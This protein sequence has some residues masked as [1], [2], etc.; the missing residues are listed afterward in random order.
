MKFGKLHESLRP[1]IP[2]REEATAI[3]FAYCE[4]K[5]FNVKPGEELALCTLARRGDGSSHAVK[6]QSV[7]KNCP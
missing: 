1:A 4:G 3:G 2:L 5:I 7:P 6:D